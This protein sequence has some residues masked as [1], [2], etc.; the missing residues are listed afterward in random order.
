MHQQFFRRAEYNLATALLPPAGALPLAHKAA[1]G[2]NGDV[3]R[4]CQILIRD[5]EL[6]TILELV[7][8]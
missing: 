5:V 7:L 6:D 8:Q 3:R 4:A 2:E 1:Y